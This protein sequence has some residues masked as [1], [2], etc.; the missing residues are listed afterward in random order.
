MCEKMG[1]EEVV[2]G[3][4]KVQGFQIEMQRPTVIMC[5]GGKM[6]NT[7][8]RFLFK[9]FTVDSTCPVCSQTPQ[10]FSGFTQNVHYG[11]LIHRCRSFTKK[12]SYV[13]K[14]DTECSNKN[15]TSYKITLAVQELL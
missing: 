2:G 14:R 3:S 6:R 8:N 10:S 11:F 9:K 15:T 1:E 5:K 13:S 12:A 4:G 7:T